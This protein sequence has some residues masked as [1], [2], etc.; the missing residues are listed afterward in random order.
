MKCIIKVILHSQQ[1][2]FSLIQLLHKIKSVTN[3]K[4]PSKFTCREYRKMKGTNLHNNEIDQDIKPHKPQC[5]NFNFTEE[6]GEGKTH[7]TL[8][9]KLLPN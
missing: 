8:S 5:N 9:L 3:T 4:T 2:S 1:L 6:K 7:P